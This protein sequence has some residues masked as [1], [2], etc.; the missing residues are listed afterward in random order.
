MHQPQKQALPRAIRAHDDR[1]GATGEIQIDSVHQV[2]APRA[3]REATH[4]SCNS[5]HVSLP[6]RP[7]RTAHDES[8]KHTRS[9]L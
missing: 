6:L 3:L 8:F 7:I 1:Q 4:P 5:G 2:D 9:G